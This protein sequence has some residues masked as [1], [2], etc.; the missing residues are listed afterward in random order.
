MTNKR[1]I[2]G[3]AAIGGMSAAVLLLTGLPAAN[4]DE[5]AD[6]RANQQLL[7]QRLDQLSQIPG[8]GHLYQGPGAAKTA[9]K[10][11]VGGSFPRSFLIPGTDTSIRVGGFADLTMDYW[12]QNGPA[13]G[14]QS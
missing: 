14:S 3:V 2:G 10:Q 8:A 9:N 4:A 6:L 7:Q 5:L 1:N 12:I 13:N 11:I